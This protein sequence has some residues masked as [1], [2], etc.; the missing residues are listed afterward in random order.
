MPNIP[1]WFTLS[2]GLVAL[3]LWVASFVAVIYVPNYKPD[4]I[5][6]YAAGL[7]VAACFTVGAIK[8]A[9][10]KDGK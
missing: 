6:G 8:A 3:G 1:R 7:V 5:I 2:V 4:P 10:E 9:K